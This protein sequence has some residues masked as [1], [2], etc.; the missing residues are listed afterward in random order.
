MVFAS[1]KPLK[2]SPKDSERKNKTNNK[3]KKTKQTIK[4]LS[5]SLQEFRKEKQN[6]QNLFFC[7]YNQIKL[8][9][10]YIKTIT[11]KPLFKKNVFRNYY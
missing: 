4:T 3:K 6:K 7:H 5:K 11:Y 10:K 9:Y 2:G 1:L 8:N